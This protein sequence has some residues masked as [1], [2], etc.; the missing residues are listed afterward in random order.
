MSTITQTT[1]AQDLAYEEALLRAIVKKEPVSK[2]DQFLYEF[3]EIF[4]SLFTHLVERPTPPQADQLLQQME[5]LL[6]EF[7]GKRCGK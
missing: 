5:S 1:I 2:T 7:R 4:A 3:T 6:A